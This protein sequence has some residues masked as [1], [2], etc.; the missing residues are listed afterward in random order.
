MGG[1]PAIIRWPGR[2]CMNQDCESKAGCIT[3]TRP[4]TLALATT[5]S[6]SGCR[7][8]TSLP[9]AS[10]IDR[11]RPEFILVLSILVYF[12]HVNHSAN[13][14]QSA[15]SSRLGGHFEITNTRLS[16]LHTLKSV[17]GVCTE[18]YLH[19]AE[20]RSICNALILHSTVCL[21]WPDGSVMQLAGHSPVCPSTYHIILSHSIQTL[22]HSVQSAILSF[23]VQSLIPQLLP[24]SPNPSP[25]RIR[26]RRTRAY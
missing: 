13:N 17:I 3:R 15:R 24:C 23:F 7:S 8:F 11:C 20:S 21:H 25:L 16:T 18:P 9:P 4:L 22:M 14:Q 5:L 26:S 2:A 6:S 10:T 19:P 12:I 1:L